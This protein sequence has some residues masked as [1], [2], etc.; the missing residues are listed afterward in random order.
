MQALPISGPSPSPTQCP[1]F[2]RL[3]DRAKTLE[4]SDPLLFCK[5]VKQIHDLKVHRTSKETDL[6]E[7]YHELRNKAQ[8]LIDHDIEKLEMWSNCAS[9]TNDINQLGDL[10]T[11]IK[12]LN[13]SEK[14]K[15]FK[16]P[17]NL[18]DVPNHILDQLN[19][20]LVVQ[21]E[22]LTAIHWVTLANEQSN[23]KRKAILHSVFAQWDEA[24]RRT[25]SA[26]PLQQ[27]L[28]DLTI[29]AN[30]YLADSGSVPPD[31]DDLFNEITRAIL[32][33]LADIL[34]EDTL[35]LNDL[36]K[37]QTNIDLLFILNEEMSPAV[38]K[39]YIEKILANQLEGATQKTTTPLLLDS[40]KKMP[41]TE[42]EKHATKKNIGNILVKQLEGATQKTTTPLLLDS[43]KKMPL[44]ETEKHLDKLSIKNFLEIR[45]AAKEIN[46]KAPIEDPSSV[47]LE[48]LEIQTQFFH[49]MFK[50]TQSAISYDESQRL[51]QQPL[52]RLKK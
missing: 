7:R 45:D 35:Y 6:L 48:T 34:E 14:L 49:A 29:R 52:R 23:P 38:A 15:L 30:Q 47:L 37:T 18:R 33:D 25:P 16:M 46:R 13:L 41:L 2:D 4:T 8:I 22:N 40:N 28:A 51:D 9:Q 36:C 31:C 5:C 50:F 24:W 27:R 39:K 10:V 20:K 3:Y 44:T 19:V 17:V 26:G 11:K 12:D 32:E 43:N 42:T 21:W 1:V